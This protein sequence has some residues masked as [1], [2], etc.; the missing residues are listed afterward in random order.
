ME[1]LEVLTRARTLV[2]KGWLQGGWFH[3][4]DDGAYKAACAAGAIRLAA[5]GG[6]ANTV[7]TVRCTCG[8]G[9]A[10]MAEV[11]VTSLSMQ[12]E[13]VLGDS[14]G[15]HWQTIP[16]W[17]DRAG[18]RKEE[19]LAA[20]DEAIKVLTPPPP[21]PTYDVA[22][23]PVEFGQSKVTYT[24]DPVTGQFIPVTVPDY[25]PASFAAKELVAT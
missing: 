10:Q 1:V 4:E 20:F 18:R 14:I 12:A 6:N 11:S 15:I 7:L 22:A 5:T 19:V 25:V 2:N 23:K 3:V 21:P 8:C 13:Q 17:N 16:E 24:L 9:S